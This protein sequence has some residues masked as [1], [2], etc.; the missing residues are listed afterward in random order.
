MAVNVAAVEASLGLNTAN[1]TKGFDV[2]ERRVSG[3]S[4]HLENTI[5]RAADYAKYA[6]LGIGAAAVAGLGFAAKSGI[7]FNAV[8]EQSSIAFTTML[9]S[10]EKSKKMLDDLYQFASKTP[11]EFPELTDAAKKMLA[12]GFSAEEIMPMLKS[13]GDAAAGLGLSGAEGLGRIGRAL[14]QMKAK[15]KVSAEEMM[16]MAEVGVPAWAILAKG[17]GKTTAETMKLS[18]KGLIPADIAIKALVAGMAERFPNMMDKQS[19]SFSGMMSTLKDGVNMAFGTAMKPAF[20]W[21]IKN[22]LPK[23]ID[24]VSNFSDNFKKTSSVIGSL[25]VAIEK[26]FGKETANKI[27]KPIWMIQDAFFLFKNIITGDVAGISEMLGAG[28]GLDPAIADKIA[29]VL[30]GIRSAIL[31]VFGWLADH[32]D[33][34]KSVLGGILAGFLAYKTVTGVI[35]A[36][37][38]AQAFLNLVMS[39]NPLGLIVIAI[40]ALVAAGIYLYQNWDKVK[41]ILGASWDWIKNT[42]ISIWTSIKDFFISIWTSIA[43]FFTVTIPNIVTG[44]IDWFSK[45]PGRIGEFLGALPGLAAYWLGFLAA[46]AIKWAM[47]TVVD[48]ILWYATLPGKIAN[49]F[50]ALYNS[51]SAWV[52]NT[53]NSVIN[54]FSKLPDRVS[55]WVSDMVDRA[56]NWFSQLPGRISAWLSTLWKNIV[57][58][59]NTIKKDMGESAKSGID[60][61]VDWFKSLPGRIF[62]LITDLPSKLLRKAFDMGS[63][64]WEGFKKGLGI[65]SPSYIE[66]ALMNIRSASESTLFAL[67]GDMGKFAQISFPVPAIATS[68]MVASGIAG[69]GQPINNSRTIN[70]NGPITVNTPSGKVSGFISDLERQLIS[71]NIRRG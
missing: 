47:K 6:L 26:S 55:T 2:A 57:D 46:E 67:K 70:I 62:D 66:E 56:V 31:G 64:F 24:L 4:G 51:V 25:W 41:A 43:N 69:G 10:A 61:V 36:V 16:Q 5:S 58:T 32:G 21:L 38:A 13:V 14:G 54:W 50:I 3:F 8:M 63:K 49:F 34:V 28:F 11:F 68:A 60:N 37:A 40:G 9:G 15:G 59:F 52:I 45:L 53:Y 12:Y 48:T 30:G 17:I 23:A 27:M 22:V 18:E 29:G 20:E 44:I 7:D 65:S 19:K 33:V 35:R 39:I 42:A 71:A 1:F